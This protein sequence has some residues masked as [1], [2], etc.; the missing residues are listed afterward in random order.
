MANVRFVEVTLSKCKLFLTEGELISL[1]AKDPTLW[2]ESLR[3]GKGI[4]RVRQ[5]RERQ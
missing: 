2:K 4:T 1:L 5:E 3:R